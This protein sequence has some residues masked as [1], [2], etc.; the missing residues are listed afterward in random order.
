MAGVSVHV[1][2]DETKARGYL[3]AA[4]AFVPGDLAAARKR[5][6]ALR[7]PGQRRIHFVTESDP[8]RRAI[9]ATLRELGARVTLYDAR[10]WPRPAAARDACLRCLVDDCA[11]MSA[12]FLVIERDDSVVAADR[13]I[14]ASQIGRHGLKDSLQFQHQ[15]ASAEPLLAVPDAIA[16]CW[17]RGGEWRRR[18]AE[19]VAEVRQLGAL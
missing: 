17:A 3:V 5:V 8:R 15:R 14:I 4:A 16:W 1:F 10:E 13:R 6:N 7:M 19:M 9:L 11:A 12:R 18:A 2:V